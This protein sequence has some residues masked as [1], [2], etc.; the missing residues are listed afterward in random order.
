MARFWS[1]VRW[2][3]FGTLGLVS[4]ACA[5]RAP[6]EDAQPGATSFV[7]HVPGA[8][9]DK[10]VS[11][12]GSLNAGTGGSAGV[13]EAG[14]EDPDGA[15]A[16]RAILEADII[17]LVGTRLFALS[18]YSGLSVIDV[19]DPSHLTL[20]GT[21]K[22]SAVP[23]EM[24][25][26]GDRAYVMYNG[27]GHYVVDETTGYARWE[28]SSR[29]E[30]LDISDPASIELLGQEDVPGEISDSRKVGDVLYL[31]TYENGYCYGCDLGQNTHVTSFDVASQEDFSLIDELRLVDTN[32][33]FGK[34][35]I[36]VTTE[37]IYISGWNWDGTA[38]GVVDVVDITDP[39]GDLVAGASVPIAGPI[40]SRW[41]MDELDGVL[42]VISQPGGWGSTVPPVVETF[43]VNS[44]DDLTPLGSLQMQLPRPE[45]LRSV[46]FDGTRGYAITF[47]QIDP[48]FTFDLTD[49]KNPV[50]VG[51]LEIPGW[52]YHME[53]RGDR[54]YAL[55]FDDAENGGALHVSLFDVS[56]LSQPT[57]LDR[58]NFGGTWAS[59]SED[60]DRIHKAFNIMPEHGL[61]LVPYS[62]WD[63][64]ETAGMECGSGTYQSGIQLVDMTEDS[65]ALRGVA[66]QIGEARRGIL[67]GDALLGISDNAV[68]T[69]DISDRDAPAKL[70]RLE[71]ARNVQSIR[72]LGSAM[73]RFGSDWWTGETV[74]DVAAL[75]AVDQAEPLGSIDL[76]G[77]DLGS[78]EDCY[79]SSYFEGQVFVHGSYAYVPHRSYSWAKDGSTNDYVQKLTF[80]VVDLSERST[81]VVV[82]SFEVATKDSQEYL[83]SAIKT[84]SA[85][86]VGRGKGYYSYDAQTGTRSEV[87]FSY[88]IIS[89]ED[90]AQPQLVSNLAVPAG[91]ASGGF[92]YGVGGCSVDVG[93]GWWGGYGYGASQQALVSGDIVASQHQEPLDD[94]TGRVRYYLDQ[95]DVS[96]PEDPR[97]LP[98]VNIPGGLVDFNAQ[99]GRLVTVDYTFQES[100][101]TSW[102]DCHAG[103]FNQEQSTCQIYLRKL[104]T[105][106]L[107]GATAELL[108]TAMIDSEAGFAQGV[109]VTSSRVFATYQLMEDDLAR[110][111]VRTFSLSAGGSIKDLGQIERPDVGWGTLLARDSRAFLS[112]YGM[113]I[114]VDASDPEDISQKQHEMAGY[115]C[116]QLEV[117]S[118]SAYCALGYQGVQA[119]P[120]D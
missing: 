91:V 107:D 4:A 45:N 1:A 36:A 114:I 22:T 20:L 66:P 77:Y 2:F 43:Q 87:Q 21:H 29:V 35:S 68:Q 106:E 27:W 40:E 8:S 70:D 85:L 93:W 41:Q 39:G 12:D 102:Q 78:G 26:E 98:Q 14:Q 71:L 86:L 92:G 88:D 115:S 23:F 49:P 7:S 81:P 74:L 72:A 113:L 3:G 52:V 96:D 42:R 95:I 11:G 69:F 117:T 104:H 111:Y 99:T 25:V 13:P 59:F 82:G 16:E 118:G 101:A 56:D 63:Y 44:S 30:S 37:R 34:R 19:A 50:Q 58:V 51:E 18:R 103:Y 57:Q 76:S 110:G 73:L 80:F 79:G 5:S 10:A 32:G 116:S 24:Y 120:L 62:G 61:I 64:D 65:L 48:L 119:F 33:Y 6:G 28:T 109:A 84:D 89:L 17:K 94:G 67:L 112:S 38:T 97:L 105:L 53:P 47:E 9:T 31:V 54:I 108:D 90:P 75:D 46:R 83:T 60:Q 55:G 100:P 15:A